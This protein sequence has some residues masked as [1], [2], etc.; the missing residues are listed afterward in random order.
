MNYVMSE[1]GSTPGDPVYICIAE[2]QLNAVMNN[3]EDAKGRC[4]R[5][6]L[7]MVTAGHDLRQHIQIIWAALENL[8][9]AETVLANKWIDTAKEQARRMEG[10]AMH[11]VKNAQ[12]DIESMP[13]QVAP[14]SI[15]DTLSQIDRDWRAFAASK[16]GAQGATVHY[17]GC[18]R[19]PF[20]LGHPRQ[21]GSKRG[22]IYQSWTD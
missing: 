13:L 4:A 9:S 2:S 7:A 14:F 8:E 20:A 5:Q 15:D 22:E 10:E 1:D 21:P 16:V 11:L 6:S 17:H 19:S 12:L 3:L 18:Q